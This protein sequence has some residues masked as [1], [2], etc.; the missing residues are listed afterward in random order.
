ML[1][2]EIPQFG[3]RSAAQADAVKTDAV[4][5]ADIFDDDDGCLGDDAPDS[6]FRSGL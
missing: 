2:I 6:N 5:E 4:T 1:E 3:A